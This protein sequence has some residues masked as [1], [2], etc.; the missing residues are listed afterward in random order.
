[1]ME[2]IERHFEQ[3]RFGL[4]AAQLRESGE[5]SGY[6]GLTVPEFTAAFTPCVEIGWRLARAYW[7]QGL[8]TEAAREVTPSRSSGS[9]RWSRSPFPRTSAPVA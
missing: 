1:M 9:T 3:H 4:F 5:F 6:L 2:R 7:G 8:A